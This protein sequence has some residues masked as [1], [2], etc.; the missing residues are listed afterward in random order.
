MKKGKAQRE[1]QLTA[2]I[3]KLGGTATVKILTKL[4]IRS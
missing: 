2:D 1:D 4:S 3:L